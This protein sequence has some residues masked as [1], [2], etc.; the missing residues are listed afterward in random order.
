M[1]LAT[2]SAAARM[3]SGAVSVSSSRVASWRSKCRTAPASA[4]ASRVAAT[5]GSTRAATALEAR[6]MLPKPSASRPRVDGHGD[7]ARAQNAEVRDGPVGVVGGAQHHAVAGLDPRGGEARGDAPCAGLPGAEG[8]AGEAPGLGA[9]Q[10]G[11]VVA[12]LGG[13]VEHVEERGVG[14]ERLHGALQ[15][16]LDLRH[17]PFVEAR[18]VDLVHVVPPVDALGRPVDGVAVGLG[19]AGDEAAHRVG[20]EDVLGLGHEGHE[21]REDFAV[22]ARHLGVLLERAGG[23]GRAPRRRGPRPRRARPGRGCAA[24]LEMAGAPWRKKPSLVTGVGSQWACT[25]LTQGLPLPVR[26]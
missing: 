8:D 23:A 26:R 17:H 6:R 20:D 9:E 2:V 15:L 14:L 12:A 1:M 11:V 7:G 16:L 25:K 22:A 19:H 21:E 3:S 18:Q 13:L 10:G 4:T 24:A 5:F